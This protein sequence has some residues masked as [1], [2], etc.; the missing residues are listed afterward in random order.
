[1]LHLPIYNQLFIKK[2][3]ILHVFKAFIQ[4]LE[5]G[6]N[7]RNLAYWFTSS[8]NGVFS[9]PA[10]HMHAQLSQNQMVCFIYEGRKWNKASAFLVKPQIYGGLPQSPNNAERL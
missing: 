6:Q 3:T 2:V 8:T 10:A 7:Q 4:G 5:V 1:M 9:K